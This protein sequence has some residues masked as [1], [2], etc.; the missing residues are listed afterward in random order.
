MPRRSAIVLA[1]LALFRIARPLRWALPR[2][3]A[4]KLLCLPLFDSATLALHM[5]P[6]DTLTFVSDGVVE[7]QN[8]AG[9]LFG[10]DRARDLSTRPAEQIAQAAQAY[11]QHDDI[12]V[13]TLRFAPAEVFHA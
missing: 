5:Q 9:E 12:T 13:L 8:A 7:A 2:S 11:G 1:R 3:A 10:F 4:G 6:G